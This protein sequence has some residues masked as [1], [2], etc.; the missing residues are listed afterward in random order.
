MPTNMTDQPDL[1]LHAA[2]NHRGIVTSPC[3]LTVRTN[4]RCISIPGL[5]ENCSL[6]TLPED[7][8]P[9]LHMPDGP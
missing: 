6:P 2:T 5:P 1:E 4:K 7:V 3:V 9:D 8:S